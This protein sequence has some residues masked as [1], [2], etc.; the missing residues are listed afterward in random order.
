MCEDG[1]V[2]TERAHAGP[3]ATP[4]ATHA[5]STHCHQEQP[6]S[7]FAKTGSRYAN[8]GAMPDV[9]FVC[10]G[11]LCRS[12]SGAALLRAR[13]AQDGPHDVTVHSAGTIQASGWAPD[14]LLVEGAAWGI[15][16]HEHVP[17][18]IT[19]EDLDRADL[20]VAMARQ[21]LR[22][23][24]LMAPDAFTRS[25]TLRELVRR[26]E[27]VGPRSQDET[28]EAWLTRVRGSR[29]QLDVLG[30][31]ADDDVAD[32]MGG[33]AAGYRSMLNQ[34]AR[35]IDALYALVWGAG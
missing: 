32:P 25:F 14:A 27:A 26:A 3:W 23:I 33:P 18:Q 28:L 19:H 30:E 21:H 6:N 5:V 34:V 12:P 2:L 35:L 22:E 16:L 4:G 8:L 11:N 20:V 13:L 10:T 24:M 31:S 1:A 17:R 15:D 29:R 9:L 7:G